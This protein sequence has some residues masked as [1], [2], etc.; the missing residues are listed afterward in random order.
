M[1]TFLDGKLAVVTGGGR[2]IGLAITE[3]LLESGAAVA[4]CGRSEQSLAEARET[5]GRNGRKL[6]ARTADVSKPED[7][8]A[9]FEFVDRELGGLDILVNNAGVGHFASVA[10]TS[11]EVWEATIRTNLNGAF[12]CSR[13]ALARFRKRGGGFIINISSLAGKNAF[14]GGAAYNASKFGLN[15]FTEAMML[16][17]RYDNVR[18]SCIMPGSVDTRFNPEL[19]SADWKIAPK[20]IAEIVLAILRMPERT[21]ISRVEVRPSKPRR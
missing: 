19:S 9:F 17:H 1:G 2:G 6:V 7:V 21:L 5:L 14:A 13:E 8:R 12:Y 3:A 18:V 15:G 20:D 16:D 11:L 10:E 4:I